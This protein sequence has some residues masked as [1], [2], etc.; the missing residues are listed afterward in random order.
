VVELIGGSLTVRVDVGG[1]WWEFAF[2]KQ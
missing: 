1:G 2:V